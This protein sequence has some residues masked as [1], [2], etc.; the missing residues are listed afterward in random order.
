MFHREKLGNTPSGPYFTELRGHQMIRI[1]VAQ[2]QRDDFLQELGILDAAMRGGIGEIFVSGDLG[3]RIRFEQIELPI[4][5]H[6]IVQT[7]I[8]TQTQKAIRSL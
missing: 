4:V 2:T 6:S 8:P 1:T 3:I 7:R 5:R